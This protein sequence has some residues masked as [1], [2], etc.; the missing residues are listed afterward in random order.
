MADK[1]RAFPV[2]KKKWMGYQL[3]ISVLEDVFGIQ[4]TVSTIS[5]SFKEQTS[6][7]FE[8]TSFF[9]QATWVVGN[10]V[11]HTSP[12]LPH[13]RHPMSLIAP[14]LSESSMNSTR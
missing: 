5:T 1:S 3:I 2:M 6:S 13:L 7:P 10:L 14:Q 12:Q 9:N 8:Y 11:L 4:S